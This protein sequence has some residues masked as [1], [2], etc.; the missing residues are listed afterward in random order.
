MTKELAL[1]ESLG[2]HWMGLKLAKAEDLESH[3]SRY[4]SRL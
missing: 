1:L 2:Y 4:N 3:F